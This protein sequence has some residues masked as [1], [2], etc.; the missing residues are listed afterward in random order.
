MC[1]INESCINE[2]LKRTVHY[3][4]LWRIIQPLK[5]CRA[6]ATLNLWH[7]PLQTLVLR[8]GSCNSQMLDFKTYISQ[9]YNYY[10][11]VLE[12]G[13]AIVAWLIGKWTKGIPFIDC[14][15]P[16]LIIGC[17]IESY[18][19]ASIFFVLNKLLLRF[20]LCSVF[21]CLVWKHSVSHSQGH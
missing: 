6:L 9:A 15:Y 18:T 1:G 12:M 14:G 5:E 11:L 4:C 16:L 2:Y 3:W 7:F 21:C 20:M 8:F 10:N 13:T 17:F 19:N